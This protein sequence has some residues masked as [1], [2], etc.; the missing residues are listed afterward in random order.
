V[1][2]IAI[3]P[4]TSGKHIHYNGGKWKEVGI[5]GGSGGQTNSK[6]QVS[7]IKQEDP[8]FTLRDLTRLR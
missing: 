1:G 6:Q 3:K 8:K 5:S 4:F 2:K 7:S